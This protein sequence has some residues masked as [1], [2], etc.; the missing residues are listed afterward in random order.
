[1]RQAG[2]PTPP[3]C[4]P[5]LTDLRV[6]VVDDEEDARALL[7]TVLEQCGASVMVVASASEALDALA[8]YRP[9]VLVSDIGMSGEDGYDLIRKVRALTEEEGGKLPAVALTA[10]AGEEDRKQ[11]LAA[12]FE[13]HLAKPVDPEELAAA[14]S[15]L[16]RSADK[17]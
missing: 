16:A 1:M 8:E 4:P 7:L 15:S 13:M 10:Y 5:L 3:N 11:A 17:V 2:T 9:D 12:G 6:L 14:I